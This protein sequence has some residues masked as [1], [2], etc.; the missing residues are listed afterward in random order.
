MSFRAI[1][2]CNICRE[3]T[4]KGDILGV[5]FIDLRKFRLSPPE[6]TDGVHIC[7]RCLGQLREQLGPKQVQHS[8]E[9]TK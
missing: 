3:D 2:Q 5:R 7:N 1:Y 9:H 8:P 6:S 4:H